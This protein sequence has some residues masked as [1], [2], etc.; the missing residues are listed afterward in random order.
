MIGLDT[1]I[2]VR[3]VT[4]DDPIQTE[5]AAQFIEAR[6]SPADP[7]FVD[8]VAL[9]ELVW[10]LSAGYGYERA[11]ISEVVAGLLASRD[12]RCEDP[13][14]VEA[15]LA[16]YRVHGIDFSDALIA[17]VNRARGCEATATFDRRAAK[18][19]GFLR[20]G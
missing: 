2:L 11:A 14:Q 12:L 7:G 4:E 10:V 20:V 17:K 15:A 6:C 1:N 3:Y 9:C 5:Q 19:S 8:R 16:A 13:E 18:L